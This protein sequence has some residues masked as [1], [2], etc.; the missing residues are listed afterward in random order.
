[1]EL[2]VRLLHFYHGSGWRGGVTADEADMGRLADFLFEVGM[3]KRVPRTGFQFLGSGRESVAEHTLR[4]CVVAWTLARLEPAANGARL[5]ELALFH[6]LA[7]ARTGD[8][9]SVSKLY[10]AAAA[11]RAVS[12]A[13]AGLPFAPELEGLAEEL[14][15]G[16][17]LE[18]VLAHDADQ[19]DLILSLKEEQEVGNPRAAEWLPQVEGRLLTETGRRLAAAIQATRADRW[20]LE[21]LLGP[22]R[23]GGG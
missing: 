18:A 14:K 7:E 4:V 9:N 11:E 22:E 1:M 23:G 15:R 21:R 10:L 19:I 6:D 3:L 16:E 12:D 8:L 17:T 20:W 13:A 2:V 5:I